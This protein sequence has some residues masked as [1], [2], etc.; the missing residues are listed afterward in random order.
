MNGTYSNLLGWHDGFKDAGEVLF[1]ETGRTMRDNVQRILNI[2]PM[3]NIESTTGDQFFGFNHRNEGLIIEPN[4]D[5]YPMV[6]FTRPCLNMMS[7]NLRKERLF[8]PLLSNNPTSYQSIIRA[9][10]DPEQQRGLRKTISAPIRTPFVDMHNPFIPFLSNNLIS[11]SGWPDIDVQVYNS[12][13]G[14]YNDTFSY[15]D[16]VAKNYTAFEITANFRNLSGD[17]ITAMFA[18]WV[19]YEAAVFLSQLVPYPDMIINN[20]IDYNTRIYSIILDPDKQYVQSIAATGAS[21]PISVPMGN[22]FN[23]EMDRPYNDSNAQIP[24]RFHCNGTIYNDPILIKAFNDLQSDYHPNMGDAT[25]KI[26]MVMLNR[27]ELPVFNLRGYPRIDPDTY[28]ME[29]WV[30]K[31]TYAEYQQTIKDFHEPSNI[32]RSKNAA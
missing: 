12:H 8:S 30:S 22:K 9:T 14:I 1:T 11:M 10:L 19:H 20:E 29:W 16:N 18:Y 23:Y 27:G 31:Q 15:V 24:I 17:P 25:R 32:L 13:N 28:A 6:F 21:F 26:N 7:E 5:R 3:R 4:R 2:T